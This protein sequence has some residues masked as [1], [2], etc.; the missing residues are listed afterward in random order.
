MSIVDRFLKYVSFCTTSDE[1]TGMTPSTPG[2]MEFAKYLADE[3]KTIG[4]SEVT[5]D[6]NGYLASLI[7]KARNREIANV[8][9]APL[10]TLWIGEDMPTSYDNWEIEDDVFK[11][12]K[13]VAAESVEV[14]SDGAVEYRMPCAYYL[15]PKSSFN[16]WLRLGAAVSSKRGVGA[17]GDLSLHVEDAAGKRLSDTVRTKLVVTA[18]V[19]AAAVPERYVIGIVPAGPYFMTCGEVADSISAMVL[20]NDFLRLNMLL[21]FKFQISNIKY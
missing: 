8:K 12:M 10:G 3:L 17:E 16:N 21:N 18:K 7:D 13:P 4:L 19:K 5:L 15:L 14:V 1:N 2:Q 11:K 9:G 6:E 20:R